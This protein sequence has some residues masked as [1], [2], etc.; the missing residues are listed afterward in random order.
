MRQRL[1]L[2]MLLGLSGIGS[3]AALSGCG[4]GV[5]ASAS[6]S[7]SGNGSGSGSGS[8]SASASGTITQFGSLYVNG[9]KFETSDVSVEQ[10]GESK[11]CTISPT[12]T[13]GLKQGM[14]VTVNG[15]ITGEERTAAS[16][17]QKDAVE[18][19]VQTVAADGLSLVVMG[20]T[21]L[22]D[23]TTV[24]DNNVPGQNILNLVPGIA[25]VKVNGHIRPKGVI[26][27]SFIELKSVSVIPEVQGFVSS[28]VSGTATFQ[29]GHLTVNYGGASIGDMFIPNGNNWDGRFV[30]VQGAPGS[31]IPGPNI[32]TEGT[33]IASKVEPE[34]VGVGN[35]V[36]EFELEG[37]VTQAGTPNGQFLDFTLA[38]TPVTTTANTE[39]RGGTIDEIVVGAKLSAEGHF[40]NGVLTADHVKFHESVKLEGDIVRTGP[41][42]FA[43]AGLMNISVSV[44]S[45]T[46]YRGLSSLADFANGSHVRVRGLVLGANTMIATRVERRSSDNDVSLQGPVQSISGNEIVI[47][48]VSIDTNTI[49]HFESVRGTSTSRAAFLAEVK[50]NSLVKMEGELN[51]L[52]VLW[53]EVELED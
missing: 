6:A 4:D 5:N 13:C 33:L 25:H 34:D 10:D 3:I 22:V 46:E 52:I 9:K 44:N 30:E 24:I 40:A 43:I 23:G 17:R 21:V 49:N 38:T 12:D 29:I 47:L 45:Q 1:I 11:R 19:L 48:G 41:Q 2:L 32:Q 14:V 31:F 7:G 42:T 15:S 36:D 39:F 53:D 28:H 37:F 26:Q 27:A 18:G 51:G 20:Q 8:G 50:E 16:V 35:D